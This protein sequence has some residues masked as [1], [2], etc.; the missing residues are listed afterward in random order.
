MLLLTEGLQRITVIRYRPLQN[1]VE[2]SGATVH[3]TYSSDFTGLL[4]VQVNYGTFAECP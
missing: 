4:G 1:T 2:P 3:G